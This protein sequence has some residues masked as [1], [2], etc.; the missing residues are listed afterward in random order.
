MRPI[1]FILGVPDP[2]KFTAGYCAAQAERIA[3]GAMLSDKMNV[4]QN[5]PALVGL[6]LVGFYIPIIRISY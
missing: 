4:N 2:G 6:I 3:A 1:F 5:N